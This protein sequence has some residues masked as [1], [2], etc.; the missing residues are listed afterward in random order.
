MKWFKAKHIHVLE[1]KRSELSAIKKDSNC[2]SQILSIYITLLSVS[3]FQI[4]V[5]IDAQH[6]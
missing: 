5:S 6:G 3:W 1:W 4:A 2:R